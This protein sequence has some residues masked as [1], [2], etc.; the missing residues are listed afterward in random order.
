MIKG[1]KIF[2]VIFLISV[3]ALTCRQSETGKNAYKTAYDYVDPMIG[4][5]G[6]GHTFPGAARPFGMVQLSPDTYTKGWDW[7]SGYHYSDSS[8][9]GFS[10]T[11]LSGTGPGDLMDVLIM[12]TT[13]KLKV[14]PGSRENPDEGYRSRFRHSDEHAN[15]GYYSVKLKDYSIL[16]ELTSTT[17]AGFHRYTFPEAKEAH[18]VID[19]FHGFVTDHV[20]ETSL[21]I[22]SNTLITGCRKSKGWDNKNFTDQQIYFAAEFSKPFTSSGIAVDDIPYEEMTDTTGKNLKAFVNYSTGDGEQIL[23][24]IGIS[25]VDINGALNNLHHEIP[26]WDFDKIRMEAKAEWTRQLEKVMI[27]DTPE[28]IKTIFYTALYHSMIAPYTFS[29]V[30]G[31]YRG[32]DKQ[33]H[34][35]EGITNYT[36]FSLWDTFRATNPLNTILQADLVPGIIQSMLNQYREYGLLPVWP[37]WGSETNC[38][39]GYHSMPIGFSS[40]QLIKINTFPIKFMIIF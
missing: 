3:C 29:D 4:T 10:H 9:M 38:M 8:I 39:I 24:K 20:T 11:H 27:E 1:C 34:K 33:I 40:I 37:L 32:F 17:H 15:P 14:I 6:H 30:D 5:G 2:V 16:V 18:I 22:V 35:E 12:P 13:G 25:S 31:R 23:I 19:L 28:K 21:T 7:A 26:N 36:V